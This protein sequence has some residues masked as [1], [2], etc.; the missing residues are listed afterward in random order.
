MNAGTLLTSRHL[1]NQRVDKNPVVSSVLLRVFR[2]IRHYYHVLETTK[3]LHEQVFM[4]TRDL[5][6][7]D[8][9]ELYKE[10]RNQKT[11]VFSLAPEQ[12]FIFGLA[13]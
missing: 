13:R 12:P 4:T 3:A 10:L 1:A 11:N 7:K 8:L 2:N 6:V 5:A 9:T